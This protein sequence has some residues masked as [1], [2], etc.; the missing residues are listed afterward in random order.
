MYIWWSVLKVLAHSAA[1]SLHAR[2][3]I[4]A[5]FTISYNCWLFL[6]KFTMYFQPKVPLWAFTFRL[7]VSGVL[8]GSRKQ[9]EVAHMLEAWVRNI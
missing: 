1:N 4:A 7:F 8:L 3:E 5:F 9:C 2:H 6:H